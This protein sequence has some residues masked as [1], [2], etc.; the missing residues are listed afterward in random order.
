MTLK[1]AL[2]PSIVPLLVCHL[3]KQPAWEYAEILDCFD[4]GHLRLKGELCP[5]ERGGR[6]NSIDTSANGG[7]HT[8]GILLRE[9]EDRGAWEQL[10]GGKG[11]ALNNNK[12]RMCLRESGEGQI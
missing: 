7:N 12:V 6:K 1:G 10:K 4:F 5:R 11:E 8:Q 9:C 2:T 3:D